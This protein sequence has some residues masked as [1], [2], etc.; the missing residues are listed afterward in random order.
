[1]HLHAPLKSLLFLLSA[2][3]FEDCTDAAG[4]HAHTLKLLTENSD[5]LLHLVVDELVLLPEQNKSCV[6]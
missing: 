6:R 4:S 5:E 3:I 2:D 1:M